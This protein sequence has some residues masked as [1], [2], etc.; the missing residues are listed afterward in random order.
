MLKKRVVKVVASALVWK[1]GGLLILKRASDFEDVHRGK[2]LWEPPG[3]GIKPNEQVETSLRR[4]L[5]EETA[6]TISPH[7][8]LVAT[9]SYVLADETTSV[10][11]LHVVYVVQPRRRTEVRLSD[12]HASL[13][14]VRSPKEL[15]RLEMIPRMRKMLVDQMRS[16]PPED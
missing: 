11:R 1:D 7:P 3:G 2:G 10:H 9:C 16:G 4:E 8:V 5:R 13:R 14:W 15:A 12:E 6:L